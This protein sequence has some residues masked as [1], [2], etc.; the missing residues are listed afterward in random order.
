MVK[1]WRQF[2]GYEYPLLFQ[3]IEFSPQHWWL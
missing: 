2:H 3:R 1:D